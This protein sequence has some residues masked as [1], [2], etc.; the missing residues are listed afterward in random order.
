MPAIEFIEP[1]RLASCVIVAMGIG[2]A[3]GH[4]PFAFEPL[5]GLGV[6][7]V[8]ALAMRDADIDG[9]ALGIG[10]GE[11]GV[12]ALDPQELA[13]ADELEVG[14]AHQD[15]GK[16]PGFAQDLEAVADAEHEAAA[17]RMG[18]DRIHHGRAA[19]N[20]AAAQIIAVGEAA[21]QDHEVGAFRQFGLG[22]PDLLDLGAGRL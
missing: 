6:G 15:A 14:V 13:M 7:R 17:R 20:G 22:M 9:L 19:G 5:Q 21:G 1:L 4:Q 3:E 11:G 16:K 10:P 18:A 8:V 12:V 2:I